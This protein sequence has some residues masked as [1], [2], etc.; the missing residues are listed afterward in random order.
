M[1]RIAKCNGAVLRQQR[2]LGVR[3]AADLASDGSGWKATFREDFGNDNFGAPK[4]LRSPTFS[5]SHAVGLRR[6]EIAEPTS[7]G[8]RLRAQNEF[9]TFGD[10]LQSAVIAVQSP[11]I[12]V[13]MV[14]E[15][16]PASWVHPPW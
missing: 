6:E 1:A 7:Y 12:P 9:L 4:M 14:A 2:K 11:P 15:A 8:H 3:Q 13:K 16:R 10:A 5:P